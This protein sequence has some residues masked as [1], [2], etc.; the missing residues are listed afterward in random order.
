M[1]NITMTIQSDKGWE[2]IISTSDNCRCYAKVGTHDME[3][4]VQLFS[5]YDGRIFANVP[6]AEEPLAELPQTSG[7]AALV[8]LIVAELI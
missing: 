5:M 2:F 1:R 7:E 3:P 4:K 8:A 6:L